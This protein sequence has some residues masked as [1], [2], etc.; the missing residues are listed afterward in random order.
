MLSAH[1]VD[2]PRPARSRSPPLRAQVKK[3]NEAWSNLNV[4]SCIT[5]P[6]DSA[7]SSRL[8][9]SVYVDNRSIAGPAEGASAA[10]R[11]PAEQASAA[12]G[13]PG[14]DPAEPGPGGGP[15]EQASTSP[16]GPD[17]DLGPSVGPARPAAAAPGPAV[18]L[19][20]QDHVAAG[21]AA[22]ADAAAAMTIIDSLIN[23][24]AA[25]MNP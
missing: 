1:I 4:K 11:G 7:P 5:C 8:L 17:D 16:A 22:F 18:V 23:R 15:A 21:D 20:Q 10:P 14:D 13:G 9:G 25:A 6:V 3:D 24:V 12:P 2:T 19:V